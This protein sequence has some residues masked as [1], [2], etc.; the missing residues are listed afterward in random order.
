MGS[1][2]LSA[3]SK[4]LSL[5]PRLTAAKGER[6]KSFINPKINQKL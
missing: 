5:N 1:T 4:N 2:I 3:T 6:T